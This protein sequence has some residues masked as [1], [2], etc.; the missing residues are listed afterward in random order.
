LRDYDPDAR[1]LTFKEKGSKTITKPMPNDLA[2]LIDQAI[3]W[4]HPA[5]GEPLYMDPSDYLIPSDAAQRRPGER[6]TRLIWKIVRRVAERAGVETHVHALR[7][8]FAVHYLEA[9][10][11]ELVAL[12]NLM[13]HKR[14]ETTLVYVR[15]LDRRQAMETVRDLSWE[16]QI[17]DEPLY[18]S[19]LAEKEGFEPS[20][21][22]ERIAGR[23]GT[24]N[25]A[26]VPGESP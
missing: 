25:A 3:A 15:R 18:A 1:T 23:V 7:A 22:A 5:T 6:D 16:P 24:H 26:D 20:F 13:G 14:I 4:R 17:A 8:A 11:G 12:K 9:K 2:D 21:H 10:P 19:R